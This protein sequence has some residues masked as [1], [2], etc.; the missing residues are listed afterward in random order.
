MDIDDMIWIK[1]NFK[2][3]F[4]CNAVL[5]ELKEANNGKLMALNAENDA[6]YL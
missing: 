4:G 5:I 3:M 1:L 2:N 6:I